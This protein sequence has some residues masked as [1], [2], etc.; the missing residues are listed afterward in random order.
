MNIILLGA[1]GLVGRSYLN[2]ILD[3]G[4]HQVLC[5]GRRSPF[6][7]GSSEKFQY[8]ESNLENVDTLYQQIKDYIAN[9]L[10]ENNE[11]QLVCCLGTT[12]K[13]AGSQTVFKHVDYQLVMNAAQA[14]IRTGIKKMMLIS[15]VNADASSSVFYS[16]VKGQLESDLQKLGFEQLILIKPSL[17]M[18]EREEFRF[19][20]S[21]SEPFMRLVNPLMKG[22]F[23]KYQAIN[24]EDV[25]SCMLKQHSNNQQ[26]IVRVFPADY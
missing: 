12:I 20:E 1:T 10:Q 8:A 2:Q 4:K 25:A 26:G 11:A 6:L 21:F 13:K 23:K 16:K 9:P 18:G 19:A 7:G 22:R 14:A 24:A 5:L 15:A 17:L 3:Q